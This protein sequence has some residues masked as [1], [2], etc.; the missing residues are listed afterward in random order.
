MELRVG[1][2]VVT[3]ETETVFPYDH[4]FVYMWTIRCK[5]CE[6]DSLCF[7]TIRPRKELKQETVI[8]FVTTFL[9]NCGAINFGQVINP[10]T[11]EPDE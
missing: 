9:C 4:L 7:Q 1:N 2:G 8:R 5:K 6:K 10:R 11:G 3:E